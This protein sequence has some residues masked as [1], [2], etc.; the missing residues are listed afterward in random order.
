MTPHVPNQA[1]AE[2]DGADRLNEP[3]IPVEFTAITLDRKVPA[4]QGRPYKLIYPNRSKK[5]THDD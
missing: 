1:D 5:R 3:A 4:V 2:A